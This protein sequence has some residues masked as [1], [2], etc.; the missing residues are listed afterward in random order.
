MQKK[1][2]LYMVVILEIEFC[3][4]ENIKRGVI[5][6]DATVEKHARRML[7]LGGGIVGSRSRAINKDPT[8]VH[9]PL[10]CK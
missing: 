9:A 6:E 4:L 7:G 2:F 8:H 3:N 1:S 5:L 10:V